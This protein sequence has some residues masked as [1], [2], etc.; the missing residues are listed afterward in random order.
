MLERDGVEIEVVVEGLRSQVKTLPKVAL[1]SANATGGRS[2]GIAT[3]GENGESDQRMRRKLHLFGCL[4]R[5][6]GFRNSYLGRPIVLY[7]WIG[8]IVCY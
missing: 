2:R 5:A 7:L 8:F 1:E 4:R 6:I 3:G